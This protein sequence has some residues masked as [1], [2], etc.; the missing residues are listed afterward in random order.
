[1]N[2]LDMFAIDSL[3]SAEDALL[4]FWI[5]L[6]DLI[7]VIPVSPLQQGRKVVVVFK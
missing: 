7:T 6:L 1:M 3:S 2:S 5:G 4:N